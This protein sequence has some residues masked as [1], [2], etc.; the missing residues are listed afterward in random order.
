MSDQLYDRAER[1]A[2]LVRKL[3]L[4]AAYARKTL[5][6]ALRALHEIAPVR[7][8][9]RETGLSAAT[10]SNLWRGHV[11]AT[12]DNILACIAIA[13]KAKP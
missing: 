3:D 1:A 11:C 5:G 4:D 8:V 7:I 2:R 6:D 12:P 10:V 13:R 9:A